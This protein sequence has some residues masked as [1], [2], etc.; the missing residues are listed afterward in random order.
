MKN[1]NLGEVDD[2]LREIVDAALC[3]G[4]QRVTLDDKF[5]LVILSAAEYARLKGQAPLDSLAEAADGEVRTGKHFLEFMQNSPWAEAVRSGD[6]RWE[7][8]DETRTWV[9]RAA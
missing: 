4:P 5:E 8:D 9:E 2:K 6:W 1:W 7:W 3:C